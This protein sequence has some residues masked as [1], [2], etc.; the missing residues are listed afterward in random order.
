MK[1]QLVFH[2]LLFALSPVVY[3]YSQNMAQTPLREVLRPALVL[4]SVSFFLWLVLTLL[5]KNAH[6]AGVVTSALVLITFIYGAVAASVGLH[7]SLLVIVVFTL[8]TRR[9]LRKLTTLLN[10]IALFSLV[11]PLLT[12]VGY[13]S[14]L[15]EVD[16]PREEWAVT[17]PRH[18]ARPDIY[19]IILDGY[20]RSDVLRETYQCDNSDFLDYLVQRGFQV[21]RRSR[22]NYCQTASSLASSLNCCYLDEL[23]RQLGRDAKG[24][25]PLVPMIKHNRVA[26]FLQGH[27]YT[28][29]AFGAGYALTEID[30]A[31]TYLT[32]PLT[33]TE[34]ESALANCNILPALASERW[35]KHWQYDSHRQRILYTLDRL[36]RIHEAN[37]PLFVFAHL[38]APH[39]PFV[40]DENGNPVNPP[41]R[42]SLRDGSHFMMMAGDG[43]QQEYI[44]GYCKQL[45]FINRKL[46][47]TVDRILASAEQPPIIII[48]ADHGPGSRLQWEN[49][50]TTDVKERLA[51]LNAYY[52]PG[53]DAPQLPEDLTPVNT[54]RV[55]LSHYFGADLEPLPNESYF[56]VW[57][58]P[59]DFLNVTER[60]NAK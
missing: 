48:Q 12:Q 18:S 40:F 21:C 38:L 39:P 34:F 28:F 58:R 29:V 9:D 43:G 19:Y 14:A 11:V 59:Y 17:E 41:H 24:R 20:G 15:R 54:F 53:D 32:H 16:L 49:A 25:L 57:S 46:K 36:G 7:L 6:K 31:D 23:A 13:F 37:S 2:P 5:L 55:V 4:L 51:I 8:L 35:A 10:L 60:V 56:S 42:Y 33:L 50:E 1:R 47:E 45:A 27:G 3:L 26:S 22:A 44:E 52:L 30:T